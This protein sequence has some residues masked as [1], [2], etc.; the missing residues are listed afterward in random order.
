M[1]TKKILVTG[2]HK[3]SRDEFDGWKFRAKFKFLVSETGVSSNLV[4][5]NKPKVYSI[6]IYTTDPDKTNVHNV[7]DKHKKS[8]VVS[9]DIVHWSTKEQDDAIYELISLF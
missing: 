7:I 8:N 2:E 5:V 1:E 9:H 4:L 3:Y 6:D